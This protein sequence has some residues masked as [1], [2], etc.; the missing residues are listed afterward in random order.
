MSGL[1]LWQITPSAPF[2]WTLG[3][4]VSLSVSWRLILS[5]SLLVF[6]ERG[7]LVAGGATV[8]GG[9]GGRRVRG[10]PSGVR[11]QLIQVARALAI[12]LVG[13]IG[14]RSLETESTGALLAL[15]RALCFCKARLTQV[16]ME[17]KENATT[18]RAASAGT[19]GL[20]VRDHWLARTQ[21]QM[22]HS[23]VHAAATS[24]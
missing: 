4:S 12:A 6:G 16:R 2:R 14:Q 18:A 19:A 15:A 1:G 10:V 17:K 5:G 22:N 21:K 24:Q 8:A 13:Q 7:L 20:V 9:V 11:V 23:N 3:T